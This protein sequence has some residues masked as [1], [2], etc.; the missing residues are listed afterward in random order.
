MVQP[1]PHDSLALLNFIYCEKQKFVILLILL[2]ATSNLKY[3]KE[4]REW[5]NPATGKS[6]LDWENTSPVD[7]QVLREVVCTHTI[8]MVKRGNALSTH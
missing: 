6:V 7:K 1:V 3:I 8:E 2:K 5:G 4:M